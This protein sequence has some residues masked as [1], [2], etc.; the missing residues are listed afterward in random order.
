MWRASASMEFWTSSATALRGSDCERASQRIRSK[1]SAGRSTKVRADVFG[2]GGSVARMPIVS[3]VDDAVRPVPGQVVRWLDMPHLPHAWECGYLFEVRSR[4]LLCGDLFTQPGDGARPLVTST[5][6]DLNPRPVFQSQARDPAELALVVRN[7]NQL[8][9]ERLRRDQC[10]ERTD[11]F[12]RALQLCAQVCIRRGI[13]RGELE[14]GQRPEEILHEAHR[15]QGRRALCRARAQL[16]LRDD[17]D[18]DVRAA[19]REHPLQHRR[20]LLQY[21]D[22]GIRIEQVLQSNLSR[23]SGS[24]C[25]GL[26]KSSGAPA[27]ESTY[28]SGHSSAGSRTMASP[29]RRTST[30]SVSKR[31]SFG[32]RTAWLRPVQNTLAR[33]L[34]F[35][36]ICTNDTYH[37]TPWVKRGPV[38]GSSL[39]VPLAHAPLTTPPS[40]EQIPAGR[41]AAG[42]DSVRQSPSL[43]RPAR[44]S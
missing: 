14:D 21:V 35:D 5:Q 6:S 17:A 41:R 18:R 43:H 26:V 28:P 42:P 30:V 9:P 3:R 37:T 44:R 15:L 29:S 24:P 7:E 33:R 8:L 40:G 13:A 19:P 32:R 2:T 31:N 34:F 20:V 38:I 4:T 16:R 22:A 10:V 11:G 36:M 23:S 39:G 1:G 12:A 27:K 25:G